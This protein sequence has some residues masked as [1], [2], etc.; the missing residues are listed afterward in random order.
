MWK[1]VF[2]K[3]DMKTVYETDAYKDIYTEVAELPSS[4]KPILLYLATFNHKW[5]KPPQ[6]SLPHGDIPLNQKHII[7]NVGANLIVLER[8]GYQPVIRAYPFEATDMQLSYASGYPSFV[9]DFGY[10][11]YEQTDHRVLLLDV[12][13]QD[14]ATNKVYTAITIKDWPHWQFYDFKPGQHTGKPFDSIIITPNFNKDLGFLYWGPDAR[15]PAPVLTP[16]PTSAP[17]PTP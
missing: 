11:D 16:T 9:Y 6:N 7:P 17:T 15:T 14:P 1:V 10:W 4:V 5:T 12:G 2:Q 13:V 8:K 3:N